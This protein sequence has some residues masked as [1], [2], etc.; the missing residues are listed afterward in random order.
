MSVK[1]YRSSESNGSERVKIIS[2]RLWALTMLLRMCRN[3]D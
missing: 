3:E 1:R 2:C